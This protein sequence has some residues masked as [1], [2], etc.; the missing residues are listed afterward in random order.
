MRRRLSLNIAAKR[1]WCFLASAILLI[2]GIIFLIIA[3]GLNPGIDFTGG[4]TMTVKF[5]D[6]VDQQ[7]IRATIESLNVSDATVQNFG[8][9]TFFIRTKELTESE[10]DDLLTDLEI[11]LSPNGY[12]VLSFD[13]V[14]P[15][16]AQE[17]VVA[18]FWAL[19]AASI[20]I[21]FYVWWAF[22]NVPK[23]F[24]Y[25]TA[26]II[27]LLHDAGVIIGIFAILG[28]VAD[29]EVNTMFLIAL[30]TVVGYSVN[31][32]IVVFDRVRENIIS[33]PNRSLEANVNISIGETIGR[34]VNT[35]LT[36]LLTLLALMLFGGP[37]LK[38]FLL[39]L[40]IGV[41]VGTYSSIAV[42]T[43]IVVA[44]EK[45]DFARIFSRITKRRL[46]ASE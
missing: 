7:S 23:P 22:R 36:L 12:D 8:E 29:V 42:A 13:L 17:T 21:F 25:G 2:P 32:T 45:Q 14:S 3:P 24:R 33:A 20:G 37:T 15:L 43:Q 1:G 41:L 46:P 16:V 11:E 38:S 4:S 28:V 40:I 27:A 9:N 31:D 6:P 34:S 5:A 18:S 10:K 19:F 39:V 26:A 30:L 35:S 44:W